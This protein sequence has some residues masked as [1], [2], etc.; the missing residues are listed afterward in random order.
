MEKRYNA[1]IY[2]QGAIVTME[3][4]GS[5]EPD[6]YETKREAVEAV[7]RAIAASRHAIGGEVIKL[8]SG[9]GHYRTVA[10]IS[11]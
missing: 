8:I 2:A 6:Y 3:E 1:R 10:R 5:M 7:R 9:T 4:A 11:A